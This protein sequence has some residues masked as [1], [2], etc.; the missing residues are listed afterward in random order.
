MLWSKNHLDNISY[1]LFQ[2]LSY[3]E[4]LS[5]LNQEMVDLWKPKKRAMAVSTKLKGIFPL[6]SK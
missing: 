4:I 1:W 2:K 6:S 5:L 3:Q